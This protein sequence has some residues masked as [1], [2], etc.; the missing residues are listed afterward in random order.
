MSDLEVK[1]MDYKKLVK[2]LEAKH[3]SGEL[4]CPMTALVTS[5]CQV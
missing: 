3:D 4:C 2:D 5:F 1:G